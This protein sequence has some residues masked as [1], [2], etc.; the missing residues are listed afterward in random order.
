MMSLFKTKG[1]FAFLSMI[2]LNAFVDLGH[3]II[4]QNTIFKIYD[5][6]TQVILTAI[7]NG[8]ILLPFI[9]LF[10]PSGYLADRFNKPK[11]MRWSAVLAVVI[12][13]LITVSYY[14]GWFELAFAMTFLLAM[15]S[16]FYSPAKYGYIR[17]IAG[18]NQLSLANGL[19]QSVTIVSILL[20]MF[21]F[22]IL[23]ENLLA[24]QIYKS[25]ADILKLIAP[26][27]WVLIAVTLIE[28]YFS[29]KLPLLV[30]STLKTAFDWKQ[31]RTGKTLFSNFKLLRADSLIFLS[32][33]GLSMFWGVSQVVL[34]AFPAF[35]KEALAIEN[36]IVI[37]GLLACSG[38]GIVIGSL[39]AG[40]ISH[41]HIE[42]A[43][44]PIGAL[45]MVV[46]LFFLPQIPSTL[47]LSID[48]FWW[49]IYCST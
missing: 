14:F 27:G 8:L 23:F 16:A 18:K 5:G 32:I 49:P 25:E 45:G 34:A 10:T 46:T 15:Q 1:F 7:I 33:I 35:A 4:I 39:L 13:I 30:T 48:I 42:T 17:E 36:T 22:S 28:L 6:S 20:G 43:L 31:Y 40:K 12:T 38:I 21:V 11:I 2:F 41:D 44:I 19:V 26:L 47:W 29:T 24:D 3:K 37:Q 9:L